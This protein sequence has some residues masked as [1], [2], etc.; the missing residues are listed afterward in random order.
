MPP[1]T[2]PIIAAELLLDPVLGG[3]TGATVVVVPIATHGAEVGT[4][5]VL[6]CIVVLGLS[7]STSPEPRT[8]LK[9]NQTRKLPQNP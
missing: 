4:T 2:P 9:S 7:S 5:P 8:S 3:A 6:S 1:S